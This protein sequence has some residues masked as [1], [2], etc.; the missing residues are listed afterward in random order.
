MEIYELPLVF[1]TVL[2]QW[3][4]GG[5]IALTLCQSGKNRVFDTPTVRKIALVFWLITIIGSCASLAHLG[6]PLGAYRAFAGLGR[7]WLSREVVAFILLNGGLTLWL[8]MCWFANDS[9]W[10]KVANWC[11]CLLGIGA[12]LVSSQIYY[13]MTLHPLWNT[14]ATPLAF[15]GSA[16][17]LGFASISVMANY[18]QQNLPATIKAG[19]LLGIAL[20]ILAL[21]MRYH[22]P[23]ADAGSAL[24]WWQLLASVVVSV[25]LLA[26]AGSRKIPLLAGMLLVGIILSGEL[27]GRMLFY[28]N[29]MSGAP[30][31]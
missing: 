25:W 12:I 14:F 19:L 21:W 5:V 10:M 4:I 17:L 13:Q 20:I 30:W 23:G 28:G 18:V 6:S 8:L 16:L 1:F 29:V 3:G 7:S 27:A 9:V 15:F 24:F 31:F 2:A 11:V 22:I 26:R